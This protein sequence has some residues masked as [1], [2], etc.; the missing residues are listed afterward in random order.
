MTVT[1]E[2]DLP[3]ALIQQA[4]QMG[5]LDNQRVGELL[6]DE[7]RRRIAGQELKKTLDEVRSAPGEIPTMDEI[8]SEIKSVRAGRRAR[9]GR[10]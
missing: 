7:V 3:E 9:E 6:A 4:R 10:R 2:L 8:T 1:I 5:L